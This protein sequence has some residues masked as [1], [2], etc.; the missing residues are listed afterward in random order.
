MRIAIAPRVSSDMQ[1][2]TGWSY[3]DQ[4]E[5]GTAWAKQNNHEVSANYLQPAVSAAK[6]DRDE[7]LEIVAALAGDALAKG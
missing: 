5:R 3:E 2:E 7:L 4:L 6:A 1:Y